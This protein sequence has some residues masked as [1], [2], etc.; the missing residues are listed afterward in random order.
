MREADL[1]A[2]VKAHLEA[3]GYE[4]KAE[5]NGCDVVA[6][7]GEEP[8]VVIELKLGFTLALIYQ[9]VARQSVTDAVYVAVPP[10]SGKGVRGQRRDAVSLCRR[11]GLGLMTVRPGDPPVVEVVTDPAWIGVAE[12]LVRRL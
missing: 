7:R 10:F 5:I 3:Q 12:M 6:C 1:Y 11:L 2:P 4:V 8:P 9:A